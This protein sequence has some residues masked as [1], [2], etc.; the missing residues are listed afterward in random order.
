[1]ENHIENI[2]SDRDG[3]VGP[4]DGVTKCRVTFSEYRGVTQGEGSE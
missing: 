4:T 1:M 2:T 3:D